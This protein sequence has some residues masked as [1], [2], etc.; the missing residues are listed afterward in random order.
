[1]SSICDDVCDESCH[2]LGCERD[3]L[4]RLD[5]LDIPQVTTNPFGPLYGPE[6]GVSDG[7]KV[8]TLDNLGNR[9]PVR[10]VK[11]FNPFTTS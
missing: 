2:C 5:A 7:T 9:Q 8:Y 1:M 4:K 3:N 11:T 6:S 10:T